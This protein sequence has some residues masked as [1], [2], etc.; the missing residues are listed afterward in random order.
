LIRERIRRIRFSDTTTTPTSDQSKP[1][2]TPVA[3]ALTLLNQLTCPHC[4]HAFAPEE[5]LWISEHPDLIGDAKLGVDQSR[6]F[7]PSRFSVEGDA[8][9]A[10]GYRSTRM[11]CPNCHLEVPRPLY[12]LPSIFYSI[13]GAPACGKSYFLASMTWQLRQALPRYFQVT[14]ND[15]DAQANARLHQYEEQQFLNPNPDQLVS[16]AKTE[17]QGDLY[18]QVNMGDHSITLPRPFMF[19]LQPGLKHPNYDKAKKVS[20]VV[21]LY[22]NAGESFLPGA[23]SVSSPVTRHLALS[24]CLFF[25]FDPTQDPRFRRACQGKSDDPQMAS[26]SSRLQREVSVRQDTILLEAIQRVRR[27]AGLREDE[28]HQR[29]LIVVV[30]KWDSWRNLLPE[31][32]NEAPYLDVP[33]QAVRILNRSRI[34]HVSDQVQGLLQTLC[35]EIVAAGQGFAKELTFIPVSA[36]GISPELDPAT[37]SLGIRPR[38][39]EPY[40]VEVPMLLALSQWSRGLIGSQQILPPV[41]EN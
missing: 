16:I 23:D 7:L 35:P 6:R 34:E 9:D 37:G 21:C 12:Q 17:T 28:L 15:A 30:T 38:D 4:W 32:T 14:M 8:I 33:G 20:R 26:R 18:D 36:T 24:A 27:H 25:C 31:L 29:P 41:K 5:S 1:L 19:T 13:L 40:W 39:I 2:M 11:A 10:A 22:D 3:S